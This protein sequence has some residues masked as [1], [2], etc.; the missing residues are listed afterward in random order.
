MRDDFLKTT[1]ILLA[2]RAGNR[3]SN[4]NCR[5]PTVGAIP[6][7]DGTIDIGVAAHI[8]AAAQGG[9][10]YDPRLSRD[11]RRSASN[12]IWL[13]QT[14]GK[15]IDDA[16]CIFTVEDLNQWKTSAELCSY[17]DVLNGT[18][19]YQPSTPQVP[20]NDA[21]LEVRGLATSNLSE[22]LQRVQR[23]ATEDVSLHQNSPSWPKH[24]VELDMRLSDSSRRSS[25]NVKRCAEAIESAREM[26]IV[27]PPGTGKTTTLVQLAEAIIGMGKS[28][29]VLLKLGEWSAQSGGIFEALTTRRAFN[30]IS[31]NDFKL[32]AVQGKL[33]LLLDGWNELDSSA[34]KNA[35]LNLELLR[36]EYPL[37]AF[38]MTTR[39]RSHN[40]PLSGPT[41]EIDTLSEARQLELAVALSGE[42]GRDL[43]DR[44]WRTPA[45]RGLVSTPLYLVAF[46]TQLPG[47]EFPNTREEIIRLFVD[48]HESSPASQEALQSVILGFHQ[49]VLSALAFEAN[50]NA[51]TTLT[52][53]MARSVVS[54]TEEMLRLEGQITEKPQPAEVINILV[55]HHTLVRT[56]SDDVVAFQ[57]QQIQEWYASLVLDDMLL[58]SASGDSD[59]NTELRERIIDNPSW[60]ESVLFACERLS[61]SG[62]SGVDAVSHAI[63]E[64]LT[65]DPM[66]AAEMIYRS[67]QPVWD[68]IEQAVLRFV[69]QWHKPGKI[70]RAVRFMLTTGKECFLGTI[71][72][73]ISSSDNQVYLRALRSASRF[74]VSILGEE[75]QS[76]LLE[77]PLDTRPHVVAEIA[78][79]GEVEG[80]VLAA[81]VAQIDEP[82]VQIEVCQALLFRAADRLV[83]NVIEASDASVLEALAKKGYSREVLDEKLAEKLATEESRLAREET[84]PYSRLWNVTHSST[85]SALSSEYVESAISSA[86]FPIKEDYASA[87]VYEAHKKYPEAVAKGLVARIEKGLPVVYRT[88]ELLAPLQTIDEGKVCEL[89]VEAGEGDSNADSAASIIGPNTLRGLVDEFLTLRGSWKKERKYDKAQSDRQSAL[90][91]RISL[92]RPSVFA[93]VFL[94]RASSTEIEQL[95]DLA[96]ALTHHGRDVSGLKNFVTD[97]KKISAIVDLIQARAM[98]AIEASA[99]SRSD[100][101]SIAS[102]IG[103]LGRVELVPILAKLLEEELRRKREAL[104]EYTAAVEEGRRPDRSDISMSYNFDYMRAFV[105]LGGEAAIDCLKRYV[106]D[107]EFGVEAANAL[108]MIFESEGEQ[109]DEDTNILPSR[110]Y[111]KVQANRVTR[112]SGPIDTEPSAEHILAVVNTL[113]AGTPTEESSRRALSLATIAFQMPYGNK[114]DLIDRLLN[115]ELPIA[116]KQPLISVLVRQGEIVKAD[117]ILEGIHAWLEEAERQKWYDRQRVWELKSWF[118]LLPF[119]D[120]PSAM[121][122]A[123]AI[124]PDSLI[125]TWELRDLLSALA[126]APDD[127][128]ERVLIEM[129]DQKPT[130]VTDYNW[131]SAILQRKSES[132]F[133]AFL[134]LLSDPRFAPATSKLQSWSTTEGLGAFI[135]EH[136]HLRSELLRR[137]ESDDYA[138]CRSL[139]EET[140]A[141]SP[142]V[143]SILAMVRSY[144]KRGMALDYTLRSAL[145][146]IALAHRP[147]EGWSEAFEVYSVAAPELRKQLFDLAGSDYEEAKLANDCLVAID[148]I[149]DEYG[150]VEFERRHPDIRSGRPWPKIA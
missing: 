13:C 130:L 83:S 98:E 44:A 17:T 104:A 69:D 23:A 105:S 49:R 14:C 133:L 111:S 138:A 63:K 46:L 147:H 52:A 141:K 68:K 19:D 7:Q 36:R 40:P 97:E 21:E 59:A 54:N 116:A 129:A 8:T 126:H 71:W 47:A 16:D 76:R 82:A 50:E 110:D 53:Q 87:A 132:A 34:R 113:I 101:S 123:L 33:V 135:N 115:L 10:R 144:S 9:P 122:D 1:R 94:D 42:R 72:P 117:T 41:I 86:D 66:F 29:A 89:A 146:K 25:F 91:R 80:M 131:R 45:I 62:Q 37:L 127:E 100:L 140:L 79:N 70:D 74:R 103:R 3:C 120:R 11:E 51:N 18:V 136:P 149:R 75:A 15:V 5:R 6:G 64:A 150:R 55:D 85:D 32:L 118:E 92:S 143:A 88:R 78:F 77:L 90:S 38:V 30:G 121:R 81:A 119:S 39:R 57:H 108:R 27:A 24:V 125:P 106:V 145:E 4:P 95:G 102:A 112:E 84:D 60:E 109:S 107:P 56:G 12:G 148:T 73:F 137:Y 134:D 35:I 61:R 93:D 43:L 142:D 48:T 114:S 67:S 139:I 58:R 128:A 124:V 31:E 28:A 96:D 26:C 65:I 2:Q 99:V 22:V 20:F